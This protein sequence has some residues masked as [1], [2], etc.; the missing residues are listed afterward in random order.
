M[1]KIFLSYSRRDSEAAHK[2]VDALEKTGHDVWVD[3]EAISPA[4]DW[5]EKIKNGIEESDAFVFLVSPNSIKSEVC[6]V[7]IGHAALNNKRIVPVVLQNVSSDETN[8]TIR[9][10]NWIFLRVDDDYDAGMA[11]IKE[12]IELDFEWVEEH[13][14]LQ[15][16]A[17]EWDR[18]KDVSLLL[19]GGDLRRARR[20]VTGAREKE[21]L[22]TD[23]LYLY[24]KH[25]Q[26]SER[27]NI[28]LW[29]VSAL[30]L[31]VMVGLS[32]YAL[33]QRDAATENA[34]RA[35][36]NRVIAENQAA[37]AR[38]NEQDAKDQRKIAE[39]NRAVAEEQRAIAVERANFALAQQSAARA[40]IYQTQPGEL[41]TS[42]LLAV[43]SWTIAPSDEANEI[44]RKNIS[45]LPI[46][47]KQIQHEGRINSLEFNAAGD[48]YATGGADGNACVWRASDG[49]MVFCQASPGPVNDAVFSPNGKYLVT[50]D[51]TGLVQIIDVESR[52]VIGKFEAGSVVN[53]VDVRRNN[54][55]IA[56]TRDDGKI[57]LLEM[58]GER[59]Y[60]LQAFGRLMI[61]S[62]SPN[63]RYIAS[64]SDAGTV[65]LWDIN[66][67]GA[68][69]SS[70]THKG[71]VLAL[72][73]SP[74]SSYLITG[75]VDGYAAATRT[76]SGK[77]IYRLP[78]EDWV[79]DIAFNPNGSWFATVSNDRRVRLWDTTDGEER[80][81]MS[82]DS[83]VEEVRVSANGQWLATTGADMSVRVWN[84][85][86]GTEMFQIPITG[87]GTALGFSGDGSHLVAGD[88]NGEINNWDISVMPAPENY[89]QFNGLSGDVQFSPSG[90]WIA[91]SDGPRVWLLRPAQLATL[92]TR[93]LGTPSLTMDSDV[94]HIAFSPN[95]E[96]LGVSTTS[97]QVQV[98]NLLT[99]Q[100]KTLFQTGPGYQI[101]F[102]PDNAYLVSCSSSGIVEIWS[103]ETF[104]KTAD[105]AE[106][107][108][109]AA[110]V[111]V[112]P[113]YIALGLTDK[114]TVF[115]PDG[116]QVTEIESLGD[117]K[118]LAF[119]RD[120]SLL[121]SSNSAGLVELWKFENGDFAPIASIRKESVYSLAFDPSGERLAVGTTNTVYL[122]DPQTVKEA[123]RIPHAGRVVGVSFSADGNIMATASLKTIQ[124]WDTTKLQTIRADDLV[125]AACARLTANFSEAQ[126]SSLFGKEEYRVL[127]EGLPVP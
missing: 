52:E 80:L 114:I 72:T 82:Q 76:L 118:F 69:V 9:K 56:V 110:S 122:V 11:K 104:R 30:T 78:H 2:F 111:A 77:M 8:E 90:D 124:F 59:K 33:N 102:T 54:D 43:A 83:F 25:S 94:S 117:H 119:S 121:A 32:F 22:P 51:E 62:F 97:G 13:R 26:A 35:E 123:A 106:E 73:F 38:V 3:W 79:T 107:G 64:G 86:T 126:W 113:S 46:P 87:E 75:G 125:N 58:T 36:E 34:T 96:W 61:A 15:T 31:L 17:L 5:L 99:R 1:A 45:L 127:C 100:P 19:R 37:I 10:L 16:R 20:A 71:E 47:V 50:G 92:T 91:A 68:P 29:V 21:P 85:A 95:S 57:T 39:D 44:L 74:D 41:Y 105:L 112:G 48:L 103:L 14:R 27:T 115:A 60:D 40:Q 7:E 28:T 4:V 116:E 66:A 42:T 120:G 101:A 67:G 23:L 49:E 70:P 53:D 93:S 24:V 88:S 63:G 65:T 55:Q 81:R 108:S 6:N 98:Y 18:K 12:A 89:L 84:A 109:G